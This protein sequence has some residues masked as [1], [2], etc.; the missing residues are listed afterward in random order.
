M[1]LRL[2]LSWLRLCLGLQLRLEDEISHLVTDFAIHLLEEIGAFTLEFD[3]RIPLGETPVADR[4]A[5][6]I[7]RMKMILPGAIY[8]LQQ[9]PPLELKHLETQQT[10][11]RRHLSVGNDQIDAHQ[12][13]LGRVF[14]HQIEDVDRLAT[15]GRRAHIAD[16]DGLEALQHKRA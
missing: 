5:Q 1:R 14:L 15:M 4:L 12:P 13:G 6:L 16:S 10:V 11:H 3:S 9:H 8:D 2:P 7:H